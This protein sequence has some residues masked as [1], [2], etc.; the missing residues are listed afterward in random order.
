MMELPTTDTLLLK[1]ESGSLWVT[2]NR[3]H[4]R[5]AMNFKMVEELSHV[6]DYAEENKNIR[7][8]ILRGADGDFCAGGDVKD[9][10]AARQSEA[11]T[12][13]EDPLAVANRK[14]GRLIERVNHSSVAVIAIAEGAVLGGGFG[15]VCVSDV[16]IALDGVAFGLPETGLGIPPAQIAPF[17]VQRIGFTQ[18]RRLAVTGGRINATEAASLGLVHFSVQTEDELLTHVY[19]LQKQINRCAP[20]ATALTKKIMHDTTDLALEGLL[21]A[22]AKEF[23]IAARGEEGIEGM[24]AFV[25]KRDPSWVEEK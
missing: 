5:N 18:A 14:F 25:Q 8:V 11:E 21:D 20:E 22:A 1:I 2:L 9:M 7:S 12:G 10:A 17:I 15:L 24:M 3:P 4:A 13:S 6:F 23:A 16:A 19:T